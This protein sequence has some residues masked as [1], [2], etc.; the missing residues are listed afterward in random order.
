MSGLC[1]GSLGLASDYAHFR[2]GRE[3]GG[4]EFSGVSQTSPEMGEE[5]VQ[6]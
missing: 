5:A 3:R 4:G 2:V 1:H 6:W